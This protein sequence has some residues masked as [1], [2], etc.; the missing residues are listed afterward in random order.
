MKKL[1]LIQR[2]VRMKMPNKL[3]QFIEENIPKID[4]MLHKLLTEHHNTPKALQSSMAYSVNAGGK[5]IRPLLVLATLEDLGV[6]SKDA[7][8]VAAAVEL[9]HTY[10][11]IH[12]D[13]PSMDDDDFRRGKLTNH[14]EF[15]EAMAV[16]AGDALQTLAFEALTDL[17]NT[18]PSVA[19]Q[20]IRLL[21]IAS[22]ANGMVAGQ[23]LDLE[24]EGESLAITDLEAIHLNKTGA[25]LSYC[26]E[27]GA[28]LA[29]LEEEKMGHLKE[30][31]KN[32]GLAFQIQDDILDVTSTTEELGK[33]AGSDESSDKTTY[34]MLLGLDGARERLAHHHLLANESLSFLENEQSLLALFA[35]YIVERKF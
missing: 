30:Y 22:G 32:I 28:I 29:G 35:N 13:L 6:E 20:L 11:L 15:G 27:A 7:L 34:P 21:A 25:L 4:D 19:I 9:I 2:K 5:R 26:I 10:S 8:K 24:G 12:D 17:P 33:N 23:V 3:D 16:L 1:R 14:K 31:A 18:P